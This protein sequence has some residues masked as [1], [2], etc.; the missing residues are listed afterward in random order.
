M[1]KKT[2]FFGF[3]LAL[4]LSS[5]DNAQDI[6]P[7]STNEI[8]ELTTTSEDIVSLEYLSND[9][10][11]L[12]DALIE[13]RGPG[14]CP[15]ITFDNPQGEFP[16]TLTI[17]FGDSCEYNGH[18]RSGKI[19]VYQ[20]ANMNEAG[21]SRTTTYENYFTDGIEHTGTK[22]ITN[23]GVDE[24]GNV[25][26]TRYADIE[27]VF[28]NGQTVSWTAEYIKVQIAGAETDSRMD[29]VFEISGST[30]GINRMGHQF[31]STIIENL[32]RRRNC[33]W[34]TDGMITFEVI[35]DEGT[36]SRTI[37]YG[38]PNEECDNLAEVTFGNGT[39]KIIRI[40]KRWW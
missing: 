25:T 26:F 24:N 8:A 17:D 19:I 7:T 21:A 11:E 33:R 4:S 2:A 9:L 34:I 13:T 3:V 15:E 30:N 29:D 18:T 35:T 22:V 36:K 10:E 6:T 1:L 37:N 23:A 39:V 28:P 38:F 20:T 14:D 32:V 40:H 5:C 12:V 16:N 31:S 27:L